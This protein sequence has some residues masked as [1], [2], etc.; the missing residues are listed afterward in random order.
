M[1][2]KSLE[3]LALQL[4]EIVG[5][6]SLIG[7]K[8]KQLDALY[9]ARILISERLADPPSLVELAR[10]VGLNDCALKARFRQAFGTT[11]FGYLP[12]NWV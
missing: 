3:L 1:E 11:V 5:K 2:S 9:Q 8:P 6:P 12:K 4:Y 10:L 7:V